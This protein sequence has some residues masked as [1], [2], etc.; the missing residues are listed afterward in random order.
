[1]F[2]NILEVSNSQTYCFS[3]FAKK[4]LDQLN[5]VFYHKYPEKSAE[6]GRVDVAANKMPKTAKKCC[7]STQSYR[8]F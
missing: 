7:H 6:K 5:K 3:D 1:M 2:W 8:Q 4:A